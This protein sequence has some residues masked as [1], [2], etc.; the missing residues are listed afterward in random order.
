MASRG[1][2][3]AAARLAFVVARGRRMCFY[4]TEA[5]ERLRENDI[6][7]LKDAAELCAMTAAEGR[8]CAEALH[9]H[10][11]TSIPALMHE[12]PVPGAYG[13]YMQHGA[14]WIHVTRSYLTTPTIIRINF[15]RALRTD[16][17]EGI[18]DAPLQDTCAYRQCGVRRLERVACNQ[19]TCAANGTCG[20]FFNDPPEQYYTDLLIAP[21]TAGPGAGLGVFVAGNIAAGERICTYGGAVH[22]GGLPG[23][24]ATLERRRS[25]T[26][27]LHGDCHVDASRMR[28]VGGYINSSRGTGN[29]NCE[30]ATVCLGPARALCVVYSLRALQCGEELLADYAYDR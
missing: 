1:D 6:H 25:H 30:L 5:L 13:V 21:S 27:T 28:N 4:A 7:S 20:N 17:E 16:V 10:E 11:T 22:H 9:W 15:R 24:G 26:Y 18:F 2:A 29:A 3:R 12:D 14:H 23:T 19:H 8:G